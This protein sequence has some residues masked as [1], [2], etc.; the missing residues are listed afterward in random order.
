MS[1][2]GRLLPAA[3]NRRSIAVSAALACASTA[4]VVAAV[5]AEGTK[6]TNVQLDDGAVWVTNAQSQRVGRL[7]LRVDELD[8]AIVASAAPDVRQ[9]GRSVVF[10]ALDGGVARLDVITGEVTGRNAVPVADYQVNGGVGFVLDRSSG[11]FW[12]GRADTIVA[13]DHPDKPDGMVAPGSHAVVTDARP[14]RLDAQGNRRG[15]VWIIEPGGSFELPLDERLEPRYA[16]EPPTED[17]TGPAATEPQPEQEAATDEPPALEPVPRRELGVDFDD[18]AAVTSVGGQPVLL[19]DDGRV[20][21]H[22][23]A[24]RAVP[25]E[26]AKLQQPGPEADA[27]LVATTDGLFEV[28]LGAGAVQQRAAADASPAAP[29]RVRDCSF[30]AWSGAVPTW[31][32][33]CGNRAAEPQPIEGAAPGVEL[34]YR[35]NGSNVALNS[36]GDGG[37]W[38]NHDGELT[39]VGNWDDLEEQPDDSELDNALSDTRTVVEKTC[40]DGNAEAPVA[41]DDQLGARPRQSILDLLANDDDPNC[42]PIAI[43]AVEPA[44]GPWGQLTIIDNGQHVLF[45]PSDEL[46]AAAGS[47]VQS[48]QFT[49]R[50]EDAAGNASNPATASVLVKARAVGN[51]APALRPKANGATRQ[52]RTVVEAGRATSYDVL[53]DWWDPDGDDLRLVSASPPGSGEVSSTPD[54][55]VRFAANGVAPGIVNVPVTMSDGVLSGTEQLEVTVKP[56]GSALAPVALNDFLTVVAG[57][58]A[59]IDPLANDADP[60][61]DPLEVRPLWLPDPEANFR[62]RINGH[63]V[64]ITALT[65]GV[66]LLPYE[67]TDGIDA[68]RAYIRLRVLA[69]D[70]TSNAPVAVPD[71]V[72][73]RV[74]RVI[75]VDVLA[76]DVDVDGDVLAVTD[77]TVQN[78]DP[79]EGTVRAGIVDRRLVQ[80]EVV[81]GAEGVAP[82]GPFVVHYTVSDGRAAERAATQTV[83]QNVADELRARGAITVLIQPATDDQPP[84]PA[85]DNAVVRSGDI[86]TVAV[87][88]NDRDPDADPLTLEGIDEA[89][90]AAIEAAGQGVVW[91]EGRNVLFQGGAP[92]R[93]TLLYRAAAGGKQATG[94][95]TIDVTAAPDPA[96]NPNQAPQ[97]ANVV[98]RAI[99]NSQVRLGLPLHGTDPDG[100]TVTVVDEFTGL[101]GAGAGNR[102]SVDP[103][104]PQVVLFEAG[105]AAPA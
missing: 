1:I 33:R 76:N 30:G 47:A 27:V 36:P 26:Q 97:P 45:S 40:V 8:F 34:V 73:V 78:G 96:T 92:G 67:A 44:S 42:E 64:H 6:A 104:D 79:A 43:T 22:R 23:Q 49:Y 53:A 5:N 98:L 19:L 21:T 89:Q 91:T 57:S 2:L 46:V 52:M 54:G 20:V 25:G 4:M 103:E 90:A 63:T 35:V 13:P 86:V 69:P 68:T 88:R 16:A 17:T 60:N 15:S 48:V 84:I 11:R 18:I 80:L 3:I 70:G 101:Q 56:T 31:V 10:S 9:D 74:D 14:D 102:V 71:Q 37:T 77:V 7:N 100:D 32:R 87:L 81:A 82:T 41:G 12:V 58:E 39:F 59:A 28:P 105:P 29:V 62:S 66:Y 50:V 55:I 51:A 75:N 94:Q 85:D 99:R 83:E 93:T 65:A 61:E 95:L 72:K 38:A 24:P